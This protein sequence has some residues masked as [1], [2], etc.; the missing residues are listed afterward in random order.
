[1]GIGTLPCYGLVEYERPPHI[2]KYNNKKQWGFMKKITVFLTAGV[3]L[4]FGL[5]AS[6]QD[7][8]PVENVEFVAEYAP[9]A[10][11]ERYGVL[12]LGGAGGGMPA[13]LANKIAVMGYS[14]L[15]LAYFNA[16][17]LP[18]E[19]NEIPLEYFDAPKKWLMNRP[20][21]RNDGI[22]V[23]GWS[24]GAELALLLGSGDT[25]Y[26]GVVGIAPSSVV[27]AGILKDW[28]KVPSASWTV[29]GKPLDHVPFA[30]GVNITVLSDLYDASLQQ[31]ALV[32]K[33]V[34]PVEGINGPVLLL[35]GGHDEIW[36]ANKMANAVCERREQSEK[37]C[38]HFN[39]P[40]AGHL[41]DEEYVIGGTVESNAAANRQSTAQIE[42]FLKAAQ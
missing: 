42:A 6:A 25:D 14:V 37:S 9:V 19:L 36:P 39:Y 8:K 21:T 27:W 38:L 41:L 13:H 32:E 7:F 31:T 30:S 10:S 20:E 18:A 4:F 33:A 23:V 28:K 15:S 2:L 17:E 3:C 22:L 12:V 11:S 35:S 29:G 24:K 1:M 40:E 5:T 26:R 16:P 34:I